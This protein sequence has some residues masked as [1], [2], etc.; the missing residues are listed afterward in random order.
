MIVAKESGEHKSGEH[1]SG[2]H[3]FVTKGDLLLVSRSEGVVVSVLM[4]VVDSLPNCLMCWPEGMVPRTD[5]FSDDIRSRL[6]IREGKGVAS[7]NCAG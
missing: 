2:E 7:I 5:K 4:E 1:N 3:K 6:G